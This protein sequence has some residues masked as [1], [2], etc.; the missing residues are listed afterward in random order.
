MPAFRTMSRRHLVACT[1]LVTAATAQSPFQGNGI[2]Q[3]FFAHSVARIGGTLDLALGSPAAPNGIAILCVSA[4]LGPGSHPL[5]GPVGLD[6]GSSFGAA[7]FALD[8]SGLVAGQVAIPNQPALVNLPPAFA[9]A[10]VPE[11]SQISLSRTSRVAWE[12]GD[13]WSSTGSMVQARAGHTAT[14]LG[15]GPI[16]KETRVLVTG[17]GGGTLL[18]PQASRTAELF[19]PLTRTSTAVPDMARDRALH[20]AVL[21]R[22][23]HVLVCGGTDSAGN[24]TAEAEIYDPVANAWLPAASMGAPRMGHAATLLGNGKVLVTGGLSNYVNPLANLVAVLNT[25]Q[26]TGELYDPV[27]NT[28]TAVPGVMHSRRSGQSQTLLPDGRVLIAGG[29]QGGGTSIFGTPVPVYTG[30]CTIYDPVANGYAATGS[31]TNARAFHG[32]SVLGGSDVLVTGGSTLISG[33]LISASDSCER[34]NGTTWAVAAPLPLGVTN[35]VQVRAA[36]GRAIVLGGLTG[37]FPTFT[38]TELAGRH[39]GA[40]YIAGRAIG[41]N[42]GL[43]AA[44][45]SPRGACTLTR[46]HDGSFVLLGGTDGQGPLASGFVFVD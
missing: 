7:L 28:W 42:P 46:L 13:S 6:L 27:A 15:S 43:P 30:S 2:G 32:A 12:N 23:G 38:G 5:V 17:G 34:W 11:G 22:S 14:A 41:L 37:V 10:A 16:D 35:H 3:A 33:V 21:L 9:L 24:V 36:D 29:I 25:A 31:L 39:D 26:D 4:G 44:A 19:A 1:L 18:V 40:A 20:Q 45:A 8:G